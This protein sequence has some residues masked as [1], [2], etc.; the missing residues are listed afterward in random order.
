ML[1]Q[2]AVLN[3]IEPL[4]SEKFRAEAEL[5]VP[6]RGSQTFLLAMTLTIAFKNLSSLNKSCQLCFGHVWSKK[7]SKSSSCSLIVDPSRHLVTHCCWFPKF[8][9]FWLKKF[10]WILIRP[11][12]I[13]PKMSA[14]QDSTCANRLY[15]L[16]L[17]FQIWS[18]V[19]L[20]SKPGRQIPMVQGL[21][22]L[23]ALESQ[24]GV[25]ASCFA[26]FLSDDF[27]SCK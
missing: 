6:H 26:T 17:G 21:Q 13:D 12:R 8:K 25:W 10:F 1:R 16:H 20:R 23:Q 2:S 15:L 7:L 14:F 18:W 27:F 3:Y 4:S 19:L 9:K 5:N 22:R 24:V 11:I